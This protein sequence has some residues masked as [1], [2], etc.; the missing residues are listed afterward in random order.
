[1]IHKYRKA[2]QTQ[3]IISLSDNEGDCGTNNNQLW[4]E[5]DAHGSVATHFFHSS[6]THKYVELWVDLASDCR[7]RTGQQ[8]RRIYNALSATK[9]GLSLAIEAEAAYLMHGSVQ[10]TTWDASPV[11]GGLLP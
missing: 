7:R 3:P 11:G 8:C 9:R 2:T 10:P 4:K 1:M 5:E 6:P